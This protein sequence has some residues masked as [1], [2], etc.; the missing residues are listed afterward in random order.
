MRPLCEDEERGP[1]FFLP[2]VSS[3]TELGVPSPWLCGVR[4]SGRHARKRMALD[5]WPLGPPCAGTLSPFS[6]LWLLS[7]FPTLHSAVNLLCNLQLGLIF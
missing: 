7:T 3:C 5:S 2:R 6:D 4:L 1:G